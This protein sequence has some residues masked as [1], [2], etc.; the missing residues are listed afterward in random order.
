M[1]TLDTSHEWHNYGDED[2]TEYGGNLIKKDDEIEG[3]YNVFKVMV[4]NNDKKYAFLC[5]VIPDWFNDY[6]DEILNSL[7]KDEGYDGLK[8]MKEK[9]EYAFVDF[10]ID[11]YGTGIFEYAPCNK[12]GVGQY[13]MS[14]EVFKINDEDLIDWMKG[15]EIP[16]EW[17]K[18]LEEELEG[19]ERDG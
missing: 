7:A 17:Y 16:E 11:N 6:D 5:T 13:S 3:N 12:D 10:L 2:F 19:G 8:D 15:L 18:S 4:D 14:C 9:S 1:L